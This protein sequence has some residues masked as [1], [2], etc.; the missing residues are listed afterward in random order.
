MIVF[1]HGISLAFVCFQALGLSHKISIVDRPRPQLIYRDV[2]ENV[3]VQ[4]PLG[5]GKYL[6]ELRTDS[7]VQTE[8]IVLCGVNATKPS[9]GCSYFGPT[10]VGQVYLNN[11]WAPL[12]R[13][14]KKT[15]RSIALLGFGAMVPESIMRKYPHSEITAVDYDPHATDVAVNFFGF[16]KLKPVKAGIGDPKGAQR[17]CSGKFCVVTADAKEFVKSQIPRAFDAVLVDLFDSSGAPPDF[18]SDE[19]FLK[20]LDKVTRGGVIF[21]E[22][23]ATL[24]NGA[25]MHL[26]QRY[27][28]CVEERRFAKDDLTILRRDLCPCR[29]P[30]DDCGCGVENRFV[31]ALKEKGC[32]GG[33][34]LLKHKAANKL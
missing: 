29:E 31:L 30:G 12:E 9:F 6:R 23:E 8:A 20:D 2:N 10:D 27:F 17:S 4:T 13:V 14:L 7:I 15:P 22:D 21:N 26:L 28:G 25:Q 16:P 18:L 19:S 3:I 24:K 34:S 32:T 33:S 5:D 1:W 11:T